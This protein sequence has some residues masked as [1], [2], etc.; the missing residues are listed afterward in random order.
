M[1]PD[2][3]YG[4]FFTRI[5]FLVAALSALGSY[6]AW[7]LYSDYGRIDDE[8]GTRL[9]LQAKTIDQNLGIQLAAVDAALKSIVRD[10]PYL[11][12]SGNPV[13][14][15]NRRLKSLDGAMPAVRTLSVMDGEGT[16]IASDQTGIV[17]RSLRDSDSFQ[18]VRRG[19]D[20]AVLYVSP[21]FTTIPGVFAIDLA[22]M[23]PDAQGGFA[24]VVTATLDREYFSTLLDSV[25]YAP[26]MWVAMTHGDG[27]QFIM[28]PSHQGQDGKSLA[29][30]GS[31][32]SRHRDS[33]KVENLFAG[34]VYATG[35]RRLMALRT[36]RPTDLPMDKPLVVGVSRDLEA[37]FAPW[38][39]DVVLQSGWF[40]VLVVMSTIGLYFH[41]RSRRRFARISAIHDAEERRSAEQLRDSEQR[42]RATFE[43]AAIGI[44]H[45][46]FDG[47]FLR[48]NQRF[49]GIIGYSAE[50]VPGLTF[51][52]ITCPDDLG[53][54]AE[55]SRS[56]LKGEVENVGFEKRYIRKDGSLTW[57]K[58]T[59]SLQRDGEG[60]ALHFV[61]MVE[62]INAHKSAETEI[63]HLAFHDPLTLLPN[64]RL[65][66]D[67]LDQAQASHTRSAHNG[68]LLFVDLDHFKTLNDTLGHAMGDRLLREVGQRLVACVREADTVARIGGDEFVVI[69]ED[70]TV[71]P[72]RAAAQAQTVGEKILA[73][74]GQ[75]YLLAGH[76]CRS[77]PSI[78]ITLFGD[79]RLS[80]DDLLKQADIA[81]YQAKAEGRNTLRFFDPD[82][83]TALKARAALE[84]D[85]RQALEEKQF[86]LYYQPQ[87]DAERGLTGA[88]ALLRWC[89]PLRGL[90]S[91]A[92]FIP[93][94]EETGLI[95][96][97]GHW[98][99]EAA[100]A[101]MVAW[102]SRSQTA[103]LSLAVNVSARQ[104]RQADFVEQVLEVV[105]RTGADPRK[106][107]LELTESMLLDDVEDI[108]TKMTALKALG[109]RFSLDDFGT[110]YSS[111]S[112]LKRLPLSQLKIDR[113]FVRDVL[114]DPNDAAIAH[115]IVALARSLG[116]TVIAEG[117]ET[118]A[119]RD[120]L[121]DHGCTAYQ[122]YLFGPPVTAER[123]ELF[124]GQDLRV[125]PMSD[126]Q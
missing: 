119:Q 87:V 97:L 8:Q 61:T 15:L 73:T 45:T 107:K 98:V 12:E 60:R 16:V 33:G 48:C 104:F 3:K 112:Y 43:Q 49:A 94:A 111:L 10:M 80:R 96:P 72:E 25:L 22:R 100:C 32:F 115:T 101:Q 7:G 126:G 52:Q 21:P 39:R 91:P 27:V 44:L 56:L 124:L 1:R 59:S 113:S 68:A 11:T 105:T 110:G 109:L 116:L 70:L 20:S 64:R 99:L 120:F 103:Q 66:L 93:L 118:E 71:D 5:V 75:P 17:G 57:V 18:I 81:M 122:G 14:A 65:L 125:C 9:A 89:H 4:S 88:E 30:P 69:L 92:E 23:I 31:F 84:A 19:Q 63:E 123:F 74:V 108:I 38:R 106:L 29:A 37:I 28:A 47:Q 50:E 85:L 36:I 76:E 102:A 79:Q 77:T 13:G 117:V 83:Q 54:S 24:G 62:D 6:I 90:I 86:L 2:Q 34:L 78:G 55:M 121:A 82:L 58:L 67:R 41:Q 114:T 40:V 26:D 95:L 35:E 53:N 42:F 46:S 51:R